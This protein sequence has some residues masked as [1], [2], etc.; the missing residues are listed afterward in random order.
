MVLTLKPWSGVPIGLAYSTVFGT[1]AQPELEF[2]DPI[3][4]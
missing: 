1:N 3:C 2:A 4:I